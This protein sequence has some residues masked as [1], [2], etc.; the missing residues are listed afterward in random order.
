MS[1][2]DNGIQ[3]ILLR[4]IGKLNILYS[5]VRPLIHWLNH[6]PGQVLVRFTFHI[7]LQRIPAIHIGRQDRHQPAKS[8]YTE[9]PSPGLVGR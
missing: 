7:D 8:Q 3:I 2:R 5:N 6:I 1:I 4:S 9:R